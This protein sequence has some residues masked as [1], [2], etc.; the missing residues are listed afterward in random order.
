MI[1]KM[2]IAMMMIIII[3]KIIMI[4]ITM[5]KYLNLEPISVDFVVLWQFVQF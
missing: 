5:I 3:V 1:I 4:A 2:I